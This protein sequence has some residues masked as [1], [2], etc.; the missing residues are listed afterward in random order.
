MKYWLLF[1]FISILSVHCGPPVNE[2]RVIHVG[3]EDPI[4]DGAIWLSHEHLL[5]DFIGADQINPESWNKDDVVATMLPYLEAIKVY[6]VAYFVDA[7]PNYLGRDVKL[8]RQLADRSDIR[9]LTTT[10]LYGAR[11]NKYIPTWAFDVSP[12]E[13][14]SRW[15]T[16]FKEGIGQ[17][18]IKPGFIKIGVDATDT[19]DPMHVRLIQAAALTHLET[20]LTIAS[21]TGPAKGLWPQLRVLDSMQV[22]PDAFIW[23]HAQN[24]ED[25]NQY[26]RAAQV[27]CWI[28]L[29][30]MGWETERHIEKLVFAKE[31]NLLEHVLVSH[32]AGIDRGKGFKLNGFSVRCVKD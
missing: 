32:D 11:Q 7:T 30:G 27:G 2:Y 24:E 22:A 29:D 26:I 23:V 14:A 4:E 19:L 18:T 8:L 15:V 17:S 28:S 5:V 6:D 9:I 12:A 1:I 25:H 21:H 3:G 13:L 31:H 10:G 20:G 16:E